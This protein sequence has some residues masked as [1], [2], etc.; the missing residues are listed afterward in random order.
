M[1]FKYVRDKHAD[2]SDDV[3]WNAVMQNDGTDGIMD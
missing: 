2:Q 3:R 1:L